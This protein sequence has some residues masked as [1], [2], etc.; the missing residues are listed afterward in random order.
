MSLL[1]YLKDLLSLSMVLLKVFLAIMYVAVIRNV[2]EILTA[3]NAKMLVLTMPVMNGFNSA[4]PKYVTPMN[5]VM[6]SRVPN[7][8]MKKLGNTSVFNAYILKPSPFF[9]KQTSLSTL[10]NQIPKL[11]IFQT[12]QI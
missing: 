4:A 11:D 6:Q 8:T 2:A 12:K 3:K 7:R 10:K 5:V 1:E 9:L